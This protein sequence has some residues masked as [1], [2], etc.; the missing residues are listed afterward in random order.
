MKEKKSFL[1]L[2]TWGH[3]KSQKT[4]RV[5]TEFYRGH[6][7]KRNVAHLENWSVNISDKTFVGK[8]EFIKMSVDQWCDNKVVVA[9]EYF[10]RHATNSPERQVIEYKIIN[11]HGGANDWYVSYR[12]KLMKGSKSKIEKVIEQFEEKASAEVENRFKSSDTVA[13]N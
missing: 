1:G 12:G 7:L 5:R 3:E 9:P 8:I 11:D 13:N 2:F 4:S 10:E 6:L